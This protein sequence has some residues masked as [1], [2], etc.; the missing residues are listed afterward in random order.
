M[1]DVREIGILCIIFTLCDAK[2]VG[3]QMN[4]IAVNGLWFTDCGEM[5]GEWNCCLNGELSWHAFVSVMYKR[6]C[7]RTRS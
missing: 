3:T 7:G 1:C 5:P 4:Y 6:G 2:G